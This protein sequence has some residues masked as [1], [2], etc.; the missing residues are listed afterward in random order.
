MKLPMNPFK[1]HKPGELK[2]KA[3]AHERF[4]LYSLSEDDQDMIDRD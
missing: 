3:E 4:K 2:P 1:R